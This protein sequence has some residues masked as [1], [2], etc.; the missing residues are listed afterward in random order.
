MDTD[1]FRIR[2]ARPEDKAT[3][4]EFTRTIWEGRDYLP[5]V[6][7][8]W[9]ID[10]NGRLF[11]GEVEG[12]PVAT[13]RVALLSPG[14]AW[15]EGLRVDPNFRG[16]GYARR[17]HDFAVETAL[18]MPGVE[19]IGL[20]TSS[21]NEAVQHMCR[22]SGMSLVVACRSVAAAGEANDAPEPVVFSPADF[23]ALWPFL[24]DSECARLMQNHVADGWRFPLLSESLLSR[25]L[26]EARVVG[27]V[28]DGRPVVAAL[29]GDNKGQEEVWIGFLAGVDRAAIRHLGLALRRRALGLRDRRAR[30]MLPVNLSTYP[31]LFEAGYT[32]LEG[33]GF[34]AYLFERK[35]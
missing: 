25:L 6:W 22:E 17:M 26:A 34:H 16:R 4:V 32:E 28:R 21:G 15:M 11:V 1:E 29:L 2:P 27:Y 14:Q 7:D 12:R 13:G 10:P 33:A 35:K 19:R 18:A 31:A 8:Q 30:A 9:L 24:A 3:V 20:S 5:E 23:D